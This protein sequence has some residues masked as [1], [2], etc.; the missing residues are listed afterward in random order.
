MQLFP[1][2]ELK[3][4]EET[5]EDEEITEEY[6][7]EFSKTKLNSA[8]LWTKP[9]SSKAAPKFARGKRKLKQ[10]ET[11]ALQARKQALLDATAEKR[12]EV[13]GVVKELEERVV[14]LGG[15]FTIG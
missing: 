11:E 4:A 6:L 13:H 2:Q 8:G 5:S 10:K 12:R 3:R 14:R 1:D 9:V 7:Q 15:E